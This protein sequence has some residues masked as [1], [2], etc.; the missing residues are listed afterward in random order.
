MAAAGDDDSWLYGDEG[1]GEEGGDNILLI[2]Q[3]HGLSV[4]L[5][6]GHFCG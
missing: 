2:Y 5:F 1:K 3:Q 6:R 4:F